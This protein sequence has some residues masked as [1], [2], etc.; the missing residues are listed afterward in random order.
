M[1]NLDAA[2]RPGGSG[3][4]IR[5][6]GHPELLP[7]F[8][9]IAED[10]KLTYNMVVEDEFGIGSDHVPFML[11][12]IPTTTHVDSD[13][14]RASGWAPEMGIHQDVLSWRETEEDT[15]DKTMPEYVRRDAVTLARMVLRVVNSAEIPA[16]RMTLE[17]TTKIIE[18]RGFTE[19]LF[20]LFKKT[21]EELAKHGLSTE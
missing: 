21:P 17:E 13:L 18:E 1:M 3:T 19:R 10:M 12:G 14:E 7:Y 6:I 2:G 9:A 16:R 11:Q 15:I 8:E 20:G 4:G 5:S